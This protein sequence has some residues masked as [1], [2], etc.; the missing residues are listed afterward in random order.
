MQWNLGLQGVGVL[1]G[2]SL[3][4]G[5]VAQVLFWSRATRWVWL[6]ASTS[7]F[8]AG[9]LISEWW[10]G[11]ATVEDLQPNIDGLSVDEV[12]IAFGIGIPLL[13]V[14]RYLTRRGYRPLAP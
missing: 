13:L 4:F 11:W 7:F 2:L 8:V 1:L 9:A 6:A 10:F 3:L 14:L 12:L 5:I